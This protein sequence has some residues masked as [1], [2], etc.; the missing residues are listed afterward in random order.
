VTSILIA[1][2]HEVVRLGLRVILET[3]PNCEVI[4]EA[5]DGKEAILKA[6]ETKPD[7]AVVADTLPLVD[8]L[9]ATRQIRASLPKTEVLVFAVHD[10]EMLVE[11]LLKAGAR[12]YV[13]KSDA[14]R[15]LLEA[16][17]ALAAHRAYFSPAPQMLRE[18]NPAK[19][20]LP[21]STLTER[22]RAVVK[23]VAEGY[24]NKQI[25]RLLN[26]SNRTV[27]THRRHINDKLNLSTR[28]A[29]VRYAVRNKIVEP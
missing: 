23:L 26:R 18:E 8:A 21:Q 16:I 15:C 2:D 9:E 28:T 25:A 4:A 13:R 22:E 12:G 17:E 20:S 5:L 27:D 29:L 7:I 6:V 19:R 1:D 10:N 3:R 24:S 11:G 14:K